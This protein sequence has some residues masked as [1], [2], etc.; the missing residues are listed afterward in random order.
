MKKLFIVVVMAT[1]MTMGCANTALYKARETI[2]TGCEMAFSR[3]VCGT[4]L[5]ALDT[6]LSVSRIFHDT[7][8]WFKSVQT[9]IDED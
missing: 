5:T 4:T 2:G 1:A 9:E 6:F 8:L 3:G 7:I